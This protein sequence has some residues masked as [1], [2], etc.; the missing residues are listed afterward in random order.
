[1]RAA[2]QSAAASALLALAVGTSPLQAADTLNLA[3]GRSNGAAYAAGVGLSSLIKFKLL[4]SE[5][6][7]LQAMESAGV[8]DNVRGLQAGDAQLAILP[9]VV[10][11]SARLGIGP[12]AGDAPETKFRAIA[13]LWRDALQPG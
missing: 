7:D 6:I 12:F 4:P 13:A 10:G 11:H 1:M 8:V 9:S 3:S 5:R 2:I